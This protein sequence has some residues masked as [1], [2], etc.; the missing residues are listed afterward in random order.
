MNEN[1]RNALPHRDTPFFRALHIIVAVLVLLQIISSNLTESDALSDYTL[2]GFVTWFHIVSGLSLIALGV[3]MLVWMLTQRGFRYYFAWLTLNFRGVI[4]DIKMLMSF[5]LPEAH[6]GGIAALV[7][8]LGVL[9][10]L[11]VALCGGFWFALNTIPGASP[12][13]TET[14]LHLHKFLT[15]FIETYFWVHGAMGLL[16]IF[17]TIRSQRKNPVTE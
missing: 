17:L 15:V 14:I 6:A 4:E 3:V 16:H 5:R 13:L 12:V 2:T 8:G 1:L 7:Q 10:L 11:G 9:A